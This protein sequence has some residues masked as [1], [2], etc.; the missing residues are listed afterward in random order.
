VG[1]LHVTEWGDGEP[2]AVL[3]H[4]SLGWGEESWA[5]QRPLADGR[6]L[7]LPDRHGFGDSPGPDAGDWETD[8]VS[9]AAL[10]PTGAHLVGHS[11]GGVVALLAAAR[12]PE[13]VRSLCVIEPPALGLV[14]GKPAVEEVIRRVTAAREEARDPQD[15]VQRFLH[16]LGLP[17]RA[18]PLN[19]R[20]LRAAASSWRERPP[21][22]AEVPLERLARAPFPTLVVRGAWDEAPPDARRVGRAAFHAVC[23]VLEDAL[24]ARGATVAGVAHRV[25]RAGEP[26]NRLLV[27]FWAESRAST[28]APRS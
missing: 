27:G 19:E 16:G 2:A 10:L 4:G 14:R 5:A 12:R 23:D 28:T 3:V 7:L 11:Y 9:V 25:Q 20:A 15:Y 21:W 6:R 13:A 22:E 8:A 1:D 18:V 24:G 17:A 26:F